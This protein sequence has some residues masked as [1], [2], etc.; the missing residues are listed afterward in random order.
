MSARSPAGGT[1]RAPGAAAAQPSVRAEGRPRLA[2]PPPRPRRPRSGRHGN[3]ITGAE[4]CLFSAECQ[5]IRPGG[6]QAHLP[7]GR[8]GTLLAAPPGFLTLLRKVAVPACTPHTVRVS[9]LLQGPSLAGLPNRRTIRLFARQL[10][11][12][13]VPPPGSGP[14]RLSGPRLNRRCPHTHPPERPPAADASGLPSIS[15]AAPTGFLAGGEVSAPPGIPVRF[16]RRDRGPPLSRGV[17]GAGAAPRAARRRPRPRPPGPALFRA[18]ALRP[19]QPCPEGRLFWA[20]RPSSCGPS[21]SRQGASRPSAPIPVW[22]S[23]PAPCA[24]LGTATALPDR[25][26]SPRGNECFMGVL[27]L[28]GEAL[29]I[30]KGALAGVPVGRQQRKGCSYIRTQA[31]PPPPP[32]LWGPGPHLHLLGAWLRPGSRPPPGEA[33]P[34]SGWPRGYREGRRARLAAADTPPHGFPSGSPPV[35]SRQLPP[36]RPAPDPLGLTVQGGPAGAAARGRR[37]AQPGCSHR[38]APRPGARLQEAR[39]EPARVP[40]S[41]RARARGE[42]ASTPAINAR[43]AL[44]P[45][46]AAARAQAAPIAGPIAGE[47]GSVLGSQAVGLSRGPGWWLRDGHVS[48]HPHVFR[49]PE[50]SLGPE[51]TNP[52]SQ[53][54]LD[55]PLGPSFWPERLPQFQRRVVSSEMQQEAFRSKVRPGDLLRNEGLGSAALEEPPTE[56]IPPLFI[57]ALYG[58]EG[59]RAGLALGVLPFGGAAAEAAQ[60]DPTG[61]TG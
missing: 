10:Q 43:P 52:V 50:A 29:G 40:D 60:G 14:P 53:R 12:A 9:S 5:E 23:L 41:R 48:D 28:E 39:E 13:S 16:L 42:A 2:T 33:P 38:A 26:P 20:G 15:A 22:G 18:L 4:C 58:P 6:C 19:G 47:G 1:S 17:P 56:R 32:P 11:R 55:A 54:Y 34:P 21:A 49:E 3:G 25:R 7:G 37:G 36:D 57:K 27:G 31:P 59:P 45:L 35:A 30:C 8:N 46:R 44:L 61:S 51:S 24:C